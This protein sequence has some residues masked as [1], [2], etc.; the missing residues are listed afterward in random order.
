MCRCVLLGHKWSDPF[1]HWQVCERV[2]CR[3]WERGIRRTDT[4]DGWQQ[5]LTT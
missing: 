1:N 5:W 3:G 2:C 4:W